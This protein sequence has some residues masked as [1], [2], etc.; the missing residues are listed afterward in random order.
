V[1]NVS[2]TNMTDKR[3]IMVG[4]SSFLN[5]APL[6]YGFRS[7]PD[8]TL[9]DD[10]PAGLAARLRRGE[11]DMA[12]LPVVDVLFNDDLRSVPG[13]GV[14][15]D[16]PVRSVKLRCRMPL[17]A[18]RRVRPDRASHTSNCLARLLFRRH[19]VVE[20][21]WLPLNAPDADAAV[22]IG[23]PA[24]CDDPAS[25][26]EYDL[27]AEWKTMTGLPF[28]FAV[29]AYRLDAPNAALLH[30]KARGA[31]EV[32]RLN[33]ET[34]VR[35]GA[36]ALNLP[37]AMVHEYVAGALR[38]EHGSRQAEAV[39]TFKRLLDEEHIRPPQ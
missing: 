14:G 6:T 30:Q 26:E 12:L 4:A 18:V 8:V 17:A 13:L 3:H 31:Y 33:L 36:E 9:F 22:V 7:D 10:V 24:L 38:Y 2:D 5:A 15:A 1:T 34:I 21:E 28:V 19:F 32:G 37:T 35:E 20:V 16:G 39:Q 29:W 27:A 25:V 11:L 23:D